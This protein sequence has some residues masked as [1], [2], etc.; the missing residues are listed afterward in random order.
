MDLQIWRKL[1]IY[2][3]I[4]SEQKCCNMSDYSQ[5]ITIL[6]GLVEK[7]SG[8]RMRTSNDFIYLCGSIQG[9]LN[10]TLGVSTLKRIWGYVDGVCTPRTS[11]LDILSQYVGYPDWETF[12]C[13]FCESEVAHSSLIS[14]SKSVKSTDIPVGAEFEIAWNP[15]RRLLLRHLGEDRFLVLES[16]KSKI[17]VGDTFRCD[18]FILLQPLNLFHVEREGCDPCDFIVGN[19]GGLLTISL[20]DSH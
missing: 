8:H 11:T 1:S 5:N 9:R 7:V 2:C 4:C 18:R 14:W 17:K 19:K 20:L 15:G 3:Y 6:R 13:E 16:E 12:V 10:I